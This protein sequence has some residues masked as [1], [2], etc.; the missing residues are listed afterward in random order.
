MLDEVTIAEAARLAGVTDK[1]IRNRVERGQI[2]SVR[3]GGRRYIRVA[4]LEPAGFALVGGFEAS[5]EASKASQE[6]SGGRERSA[7]IDGLTRRLADQAAE[8]A[9]LR[10]ERERA[11]AL[12]HELDD[13]RRAREA[14]EARYLEARDLLDKTLSQVGRLAESATLVVRSP[15]RLAGVAGRSPPADRVRPRS[16][17]HF[18]VI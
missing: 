12:Q 13:E 15:A 7:A 6:A 10:A 5:F 18:K 8:I 1:T 4:D 17:D 9:E 11:R 16:Q 2:P 14:A 3:R